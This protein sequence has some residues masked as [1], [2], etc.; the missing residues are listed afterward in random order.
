M[1][2]TT[3]TPFNHVP[4]RL[5]IPQ[6]PTRHVDAV[7]PQRAPAIRRRKEQRNAGFGRGLRDVRNMTH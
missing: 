4:E 5:Q 3:T 1:T 2:T 7:T 6:R